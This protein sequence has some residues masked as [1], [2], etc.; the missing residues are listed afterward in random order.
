MMLYLLDTNIY[1]DFYDRYYRVEF[2]PSFWQHFETIINRHVVIPKIVLNEQF[3]DDWFKDWI[4]ENYRGEILHHRNF[5]GTWL[6]VL[7]HLRRSEFYKEEALG[8]ERGWARERIADPWL[9]AIALEKE[10]T[11]V[12]SETRNSN[13]NIY[14]PSKNAKIPDVC[15]DLGVPC[16]NMNEFFQKTSLVI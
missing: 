8:G 9:I 7:E 13:R 4:S 12:T 11:L 14:Q 1:L 15:D 3:Q 16:I 10:L 5:A 2:F 6:E